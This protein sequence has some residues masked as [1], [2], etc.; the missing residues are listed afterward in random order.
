MEYMTFKLGDFTCTVLQDS[1]DSSPAADIFGQVAENERT[2]VITASE[3]DP[4]AIV[5]SMNVMLVDTGDKRVLLDTGLG[6]ATGLGGKL[7][8]VMDKY[9]IARDSIDVVVLCHSHADHYGG[10]LNENGEKNFR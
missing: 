4:E 10:M 1:S 5:L 3:Y 9:G 7:L 2:Q 8:A 6:V